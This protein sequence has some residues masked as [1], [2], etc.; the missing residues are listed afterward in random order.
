VRTSWIRIAAASAATIVLALLPATAQATYPGPVG[1][2][3]FTDYTTGKIFTIN[4]DGTGLVRLTSGRPGSIADTPSWSPGGG[5]V[6]FA[7]NPT[8][9]APP[10][11]WVVRADGTHQHRLSGDTE[12]FRH[13]DPTY[14]PDGRTIVF[15]R[16]QPGEGVCAIWRMRADGTHKRPLTPY[17]SGTNEAVDINPSISPDGRRIAFARLFGDGFKS[18]LFVMDAN[19]R[20]AHPITPPRLEATFPDWAPSGRRL[21]F[22]SSAQRPG[23]SIFTVDPDGS[24][25][26]RMTPGRYPHNSVASVYSPRGDRLVF[27]DDRSYANQCCLDLFTISLRGTHERRVGNGLDHRGFILP[28][29]G[30][31]PPVR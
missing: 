4:P 13:F 17:R 20:N 11:I 27:S 19:G 2:I 25:M 15:A 23:S 10:R 22:T 16:C 24:H 9:S 6:T 8:P 30:S 5:R 12:G 31:A 26:K 28:A 29:W 1:R 18:R 3:A 21:T 14:S 7:F